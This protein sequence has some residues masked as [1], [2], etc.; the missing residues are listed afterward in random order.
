MICSYLY[1]KNI[2]CTKLNKQTVAKIQEIQKENE[3]TFNNYCNEIKKLLDSMIGDKIL[4]WDVN[5]FSIIKPFI[6]MPYLYQ[7]RFELEENK[8]LNRYLPRSYKQDLTSKHTRE[9]AYC[10]DSDDSYDDEDDKDVEKDDEI[11]Y[12][13]F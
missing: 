3:I 11:L 6:N 8:K 12:T 13:F 10:V 1:N 9:Q 5:I 4:Y 7:L 2:S